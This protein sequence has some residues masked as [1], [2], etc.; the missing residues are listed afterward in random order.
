M[1]RTVYALGFFDGVH[2]GHQVLLAAAVKLAKQVGAKAGAVTFATHP[3]GL[4]SG[5]APGLLTTGEVRNELL[6]LYG[7]ETVRVLPFDEKVKNT[8]WDSFLTQ[9]AEAGAAGF[10]CGDDF[11]FGAGGVGTAEKLEAFCR[12]RGMA[13]AIVTQRMQDGRR[14]SSTDIRALLEQGQLDRANG[15]L[16]H[17]YF[18]TGTVVQ[19]RQLG[20]T[21][22]I[23]TANILLPPE[24][25]VPKLGVYACLADVDGKRYKAVTNIGSRPTVGGHQVR[26]ES[27][28]LDFEGDLYGKRLTLAFLRFIR[29]EQKFGSLE[30]LKQQVQVDAEQVR[31]LKI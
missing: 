11:R 6:R 13:Y 20:R 29:P 2:L 4:V 23:P 26:A 19:G 1:E 27:W 25:A 31:K 21:M 16:G 28:L 22:G 3:D 14:V 10:V 15:L 8:P 12:Q 30:E 18:L 24:L 7:M 17:P 9:L 5:S